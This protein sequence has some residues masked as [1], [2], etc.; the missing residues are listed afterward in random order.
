MFLYLHLCMMRYFIRRIIK[1]TR[2]D[3][4]APLGS[5]CP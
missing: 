1:Y 4:L 5:A 2:C 3:R